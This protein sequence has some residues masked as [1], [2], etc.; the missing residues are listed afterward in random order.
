MAEPA[1]QTPRD[2]IVECIRVARTAPRS[3]T[4]RHERLVERCIAEALRLG[5]DVPVEVVVIEQL[6]R[7]AQHRRTRPVDVP[8]DLI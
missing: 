5:T 7:G 8:G 6:A 2:L 4:L 1:P 3:G